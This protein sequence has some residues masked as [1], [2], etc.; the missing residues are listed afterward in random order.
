MLWK[1]F[2]PRPPCGGRQAY[3]KSVRFFRVISIHVPLAG[4]D[5]RRIE[6]PKCHSI[7]IH[8]PLAGD[9]AHGS[10]PAA[11][12]RDFYPRPPCGGRLCIQHRA[13]Q[14]RCNFYPRPPCGGRP[15]WRIMWRTSAHFYPRPP[16]GGRLR[17]S[18]LTICGALFLSTSP[19]RGTTRPSA[20]LAKTFEFLSTSP[21]R[22]TTGL[23]D[24]AAARIEISIHVPL[25]G[26]DGDAVLRNIAEAL[27]SIHVPLAGDDRRPWPGPS[28]RRYFYPRPPCGG[29]RRNTSR[30]WSRWTDFYPRPPCGGRRDDVGLFVEAERISI[31]V[32]LAGDDASH[33]SASA[34]HCIS[35][36]VPLAGDD[37]SPAAAARPF[38]D[39]YPRPPCGGRHIPQGLAIGIEKFLSTSPLRG[40]TGE[41]IVPGRDVNKFLSTSPL[42][43]TTGKRGFNSVHSTISIHV[44]LAGDDWFSFTIVV[45]NLYF[46]PRPPCGGRRLPVNASC[47][48]LGFLSTSPLRGTT[49][50]VRHVKEQS[51][52]FYPRPPCGGRPFVLTMPVPPSRFLSTSPLRGTTCPG[53]NSLAHF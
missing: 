19:L 31:H 39:F 14:T 35:I 37:G 4:D 52:Y 29:R 48:P 15:L 50:A 49:R 41:A 20:R 44:P 53:Q 16:C 27:I 40:T 10:K 11:L 30:A 8:V 1:N 23:V 17:L 9:D 33:T 7:S 28:P 21:L 3:V 12:Q 32:P 24:L 45:D 36:H 43:G 42:R 6:P 38:P 5:A 46:Y 2:Y 18:A 25:A 34:S 51:A 47:A 13:Q 26:D 22:G